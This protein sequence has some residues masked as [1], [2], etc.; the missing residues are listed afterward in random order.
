MSKASVRSEIVSE[1]NEVIGGDRAQTY[2]SA[3]ANF[4]MIA[5]LWRA[6]FGWDVSA[7]DVAQAMTLLKIARLAQ[8]ETHRDNWVD[9]IG[10]LALGG[11][12]A[13]SEDLT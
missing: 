3:A 8:K 10:Y 5:G 1:A 9:G 7:V 12:I 2:G 4:Q 13:L 11:E 6:R